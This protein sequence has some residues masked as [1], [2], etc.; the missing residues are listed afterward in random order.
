LTAVLETVGGKTAAE[1]FQLLTGL[2]S[3]M[4]WYG[5][6]SG[7]PAEITA[8][9][10]FDVGATLIPFSLGKNPQLMPDL[11]RRAQALGAAGELEPVIGQVYP[12]AEAAAAHRAIEERS[13][14]GKLILTP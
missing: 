5:N 12:L 9:D 6:A 2:G 1:A 14:I 13:S 8:A 3:R 10:V 4:V 11:H 7:T